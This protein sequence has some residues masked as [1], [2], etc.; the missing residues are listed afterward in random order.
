M[1]A[2]LALLA[3]LL[4]AGCAATVEAPETVPA[5]QTAQATISPVAGG[6]TAP[7]ATTTP[8]STATPQPTTTSAPT[9]ASESESEPSGVVA[10]VT[11]VEATGEAGSYQFSVTIASPDTG[12]DQYADW[13]E[14]LDDEGNLLY[15]RILAHSHVDEQPFTRSGGPVEIQ[16]D[17]VVWVRA[18][19]NTDGYGGTALRGSP[20]AGFEPAPLAADF[21][22]DVADQEP[23]PEGCAF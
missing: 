12:C 9:R 15:R 14:V 13:W 11:A 3:L 21:A 4:L 6:T 1:T 22:A 2:A 19:M 20:A 7:E 5:E 23:L 17:Q 10:D 18:H 8:E 16:P